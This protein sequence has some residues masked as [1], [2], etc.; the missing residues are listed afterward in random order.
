MALEAI[1]ERFVEQTPVTVMARLALSRALDARWLDE[2]FER[3]RD[4]QYTRELLFSTAVDLMSVVVMGLKP[5]LHAAAKAAVKI[6]VSLT[7]VYD[8]INRTEP[9]VVAALVR[10]GCR[11]ASGGDA[12]QGGG[13]GRNGPG[14][15]AA[16]CRWQSPDRQR[17]TPEG[18]AGISRRRPAGPVPRGV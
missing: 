2:L 13:Y 5:S 7:A 4:R 16:D 3:T 9:E 10:G 17:E 18:T 12:G 11:T 14:L 1:L 6:P 8:K 15:P